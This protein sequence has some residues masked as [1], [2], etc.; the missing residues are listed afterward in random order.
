MEHSP[1]ERNLFDFFFSLF[2]PPVDLLRFFT[3]APVPEIS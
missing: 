2:L 1:F 3:A